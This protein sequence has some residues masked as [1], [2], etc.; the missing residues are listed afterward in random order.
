MLV[1]VS[2]D[3][4]QHRPRLFWV[5]LCNVFLRFSLSKWMQ[6]NILFARRFAVC[7]VIR[8]FERHRGAVAVYVPICFCLV[9]TTENSFK[10]GHICSF[11]DIL[12]IYLDAIFV[13]CY[14]SNVP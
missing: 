2:F 1:L 10:E 4:T 14:I 6:M 11:L 13:V 5:T 7:H 3:R 8:P 12:V 9:S